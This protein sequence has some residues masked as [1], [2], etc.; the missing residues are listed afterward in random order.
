MIATF[1]SGWA[2]MRVAAGR[3]AASDGNAYREGE[4][5]EPDDDPERVREREGKRVKHEPMEKP[6]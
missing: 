2:R 6:E 4:G 5:R 1:F 3:A